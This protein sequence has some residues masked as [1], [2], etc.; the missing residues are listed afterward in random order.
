L[1][2]ADGGINLETIHML[3][4][5][6]VNIFTVGSALFGSDDYTTTIQ[7]MRKVMEV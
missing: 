7:R 1:I 4:E 3:S 6:G 2:Q 5:A